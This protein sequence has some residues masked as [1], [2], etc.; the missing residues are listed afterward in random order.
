MKRTD[1]RPNTAPGRILLGLVPLGILLILLIAVPGS[2]D[3]ITASPPALA[4]MPLGVVMVC[5]ALIVMAVGIE[6]MRRAPSE[7][8]AFLAFAGLTL[9]SAIVMIVAPLLVL[10]I[11]IMPVA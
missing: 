4:G 3:A 6:A 11:Q 7:Q 1:L 2:A 10:L 8:F 5:A 9:P